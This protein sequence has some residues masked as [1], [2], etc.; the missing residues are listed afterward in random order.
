[1]HT[2]GSVLLLFTA[3]IHD[4]CQWTRANLKGSIS[5]ELAQACV[6]VDISYNARYTPRVSKIT[7]K[8]R[9]RHEL[10]AALRVTPV[11]AFEHH[12]CLDSHCCHPF[13]DLPRAVLQHQHNAVCPACKHVWCRFKDNAGYPEATIRCHR[14]TLCARQQTPVCRFVLAQCRFRQH[15]HLP[16]KLYIQLSTKTSAVAEN[17]YSSFACT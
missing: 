7:D 16:C 5:V 6:H 17:W 1:M 9:C 2:L 12:L 15:E 8:C 3:L 14:Q 10:K 11:A 4:P 13:K